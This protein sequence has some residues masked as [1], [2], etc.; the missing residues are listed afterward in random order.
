MKI[1]VTGCAGQVGRE[2]NKL[3]TKSK[4]WIFLDSKEFNLLD[5]K[6]IYPKLEK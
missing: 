2:L 4:E 1:L 6:N 3:S 5:Q